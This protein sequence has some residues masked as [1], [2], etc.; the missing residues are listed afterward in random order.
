MKIDRVTRSCEF[1]DQ[2][3]GRTQRKQQH[4]FRFSA[5]SVPSVRCPAQKHRHTYFK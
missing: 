4:Q 5:V 2:L 1:L 3:N